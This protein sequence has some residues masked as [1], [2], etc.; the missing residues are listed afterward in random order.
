MKLNFRVL[1]CYNE[2]FAL[3]QNYLGK[4]LESGSEILDL[5]ERNF[6]SQLNST[7]KLLSKRFK[8]VKALAIGGDLVKSISEIKELSP[9]IIVNFVETIEGK[10]N[11]ESYFAGL[12]EILGIAYTGNTPM[13]LENCLYK[14]RTKQILTSFDINTPRFIKLESNGKL[15]KLKFDLKFPIIVKL[16]NEDAS[17][18][19]SENSVVYT[20]EN[21]LKRVKYLKNNFNQPM[22]IEEYIDGRE[23]NVAILGEELLPISEI[24]FESLP[25]H[26]PKIVTYEA[27]WSEDS[28]YY[29]NTV[30]KCPAN[31]KTG[32]RKR[33]EKT[34][35]EAYRALECRDYAR[36]DIR[37]SKKNVPFVIEVNPNPD[38]SSDAG[39]ARAARAAGINYE[40]LL[41]RIAMLAANRIKK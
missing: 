37:L 15:S 19:I 16:L 21:L 9:D 41:F 10:S 23:F 30:P 39:F 5:S 18:G 35:Y 27:K 24:V 33:L 12:Y 40:E 1:I 8:S 14:S 13:A 20:F 31:I 29:K 28:I 17:I 34:A 26:L 25:D 7:K 36:V 3:Y 22:L 2:P 4:E 38:V 32:I 11:F 6:L